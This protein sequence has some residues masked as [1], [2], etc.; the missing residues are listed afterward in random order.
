MISKSS[1]VKLACD[2]TLGD[3]WCK[4]FVFTYG[5]VVDVL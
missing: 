1:N 4:I 3:D 5:N 2:N